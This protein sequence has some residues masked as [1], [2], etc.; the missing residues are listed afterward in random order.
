[1]NKPEDVTQVY[2]PIQYPFSLDKNW[3][4][5]DES[6]PSGTFSELVNYIPKGQ[7]LFTRKGITELSWI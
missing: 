5:R 2:Y 6:M 7:V 4:P 3:D 1:M